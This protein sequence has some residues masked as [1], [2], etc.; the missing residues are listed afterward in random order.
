MSDNLFIPVRKES[1]PNSKSTTTLIVE[2]VPSE[3]AYNIILRSI[4]NGESLSSEELRDR[5]N[6]Q[7]NGDNITLVYNEFI[8]FLN[9]YYGLESNIISKEHYVDKEKETESQRTK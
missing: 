3:I 9:S 1:E 7:I 2:N 6:S 4:Q 8:S 5:V